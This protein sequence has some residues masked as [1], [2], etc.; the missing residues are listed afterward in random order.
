M[1]MIIFIL[2]VIILGAAA[3]A[4]WYFFMRGSAENTNAQNTPDTPGISMPGE[5]P[6]IIP[7]ME[8]MEQD[9][10]PEVDQSIPPANPPVT[11]GNDVLAPVEEEVEKR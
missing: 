2:L 1:Y 8:D 3:I 10:L 11:D 5:S 6:A 4:Y 7:P 9:S